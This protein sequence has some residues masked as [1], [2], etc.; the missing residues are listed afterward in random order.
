M[1]WFCRRLPAELSHWWGGR[2]G[3]AGGGGAILW[4]AADRD[5]MGGPGEGRRES[6]EKPL[7]A[8]RV[9]SPWHHTQHTPH[10]PTPTTAYSSFFFL[11]LFILSFLFTHATHLSPAV[12]D[13]PVHAFAGPPAGS[14]LLVQNVP[15]LHDLSA[16]RWCS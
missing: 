10:H 1:L 8:R 9:T 6:A 15:K 2:R 3:R 4:G 13:W 16:E 12:V 7:P 11:S 5:G 14:V